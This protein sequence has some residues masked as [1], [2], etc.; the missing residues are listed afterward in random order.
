MKKQFTPGEW[1]QS[2]RQ[3]PNDADGMYSTQVYTE[4]GETIASLAW[5]A[6]PPI[7]ENGKKTIGSYRKENAQLISAAPNMLEALMDLE[8]DNNSIPKPIWDKVQNAIKKAI[9]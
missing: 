2:H 3:I 6:K 9:G 5:Y 7:I 4:D 8:N 1:K